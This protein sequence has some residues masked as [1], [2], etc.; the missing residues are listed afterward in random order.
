MGERGSGIGVG[1][2]LIGGGVFKFI[3]IQKSKVVGGSF[4]RSE[5][6]GLGSGW[7]SMGVGG[8][9]SVVRGWEGGE[10]RVVNR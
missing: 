6:A 3:L 10:Q 1:S 9:R 8:V 4:G 7:G 2:I 5:G